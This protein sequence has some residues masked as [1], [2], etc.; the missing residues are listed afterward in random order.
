MEHIVPLT[1]TLRA[2]HADVGSLE[3]AIDTA[4]AEV[5]QALW[6]EL[7]ALLEAALPLPTDCPCGERFKANGR[8]PRRLV[9]LAGEVDLRRRRLR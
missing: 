5:G 1:V 4:L 8:A 6:V 9:T 2:E 3:R 7:V